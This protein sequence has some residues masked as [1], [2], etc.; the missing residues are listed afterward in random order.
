[1]F[2]VASLCWFELASLAEL[3]E[4]LAVCL[5][6]ALQ[7][8]NLIASPLLQL[9]PVDI[10]YVS[11]RL[12]ALALLLLCFGHVRFMCA[13]ASLHHRE[14]ILISFTFAPSLPA[15]FFLLPL[16]KPIIRPV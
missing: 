13:P 12:L 7:L 8:S 1:M 9:E 14:S 6:L 16:H 11:C 4:A 15:L 10:R 3:L 5:E 2:F